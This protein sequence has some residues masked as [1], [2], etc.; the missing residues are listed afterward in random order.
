MHGLAQLDSDHVVGVL[1]LVQETVL[2]DELMMFLH[3]RADERKS[4]RGGNADH[5]NER[6][7]NREGN[8]DQTW[9]HERRSNR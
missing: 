4:I 1:L 8:A 9:R 2:A 3:D 7:S 5:A 6:R